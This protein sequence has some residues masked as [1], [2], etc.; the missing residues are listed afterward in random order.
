MTEIVVTSSALR[1]K[2]RLVTASQQAMTAMPAYQTG[3][4]RSPARICRSYR[5]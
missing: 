2:R 5:I 1:Q 3:R 4:S